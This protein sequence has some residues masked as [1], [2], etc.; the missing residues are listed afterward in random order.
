M[1]KVKVGK[2]KTKKHKIPKRKTRV[3]SKP[4]SFAQWNALIDYA[5]WRGNDWKDGLYLDWARCGSNWDGPYH[6]LQSLRHS[7][8]PA[9]LSK[10]N[11]E[12]KG[13]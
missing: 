9:W 10:F 2:V 12:N 3:E 13:S 7:H 11:V 1:K 8:G 4:I 5:Q 6:L